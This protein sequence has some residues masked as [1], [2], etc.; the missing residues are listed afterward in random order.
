VDLVAIEAIASAESVYLPEDLVL[1]ALEAGE[2]LVLLPERP[3]VTRDEGAH[4][5]AAFGGA[6]PRKPVDVL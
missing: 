5:A 1:L 3:E 2:L 6:D 4:R